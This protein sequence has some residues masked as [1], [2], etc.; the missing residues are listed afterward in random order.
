MLR[1]DVQVL[2]GL[3]IGL[4]LFAAVVLTPLA[5]RLARRYEV[6]D[7]P[8]EAKHHRRVTPYL[9]GLASAVA[10]VAVGGVAAGTREQLVTLLLGGVALT[11]VGL[12]D[13]QRP[14]PIALKLGVEIAAAAMLWLSGIRAELFGI[15][16]LDLALTVAWVVA[17]TNALNILDNMDG[18][19]AGVTAI[20]AATFFVI[21]AQAGHHLVGAMSL[22]VAGA[23]LGF[24]VHNFPPAR[25]F[26]GDA[27]TLL[28]GFLLA[29]IGLK[30]DLVGTN[31]FVRSSIPVLVLGVPLFDML[32]VVITR[33]RERR[34]IYLGGLDHT[35]HRLARRGLSART[36]ALLHYFAQG[37]LSL[38]AIALVHAT[39]G[40]AL[41]IVLG[42]CAIVA[43][44]L[45]VVLRLP[46][47]RKPE[48]SQR[49]HE[50]A[51]HGHTPFAEKR[52]GYS[53]SDRPS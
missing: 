43:I 20:S 41:A 24:L 53:R 10:L 13:D 39:W 28:F 51:P 48:D 14:V 7:H 2:Y 50:D 35:S 36:V 29:A 15:A 31:G 9:G 1:I 6:L 30:L 25:I 18:L 3:A 46:Y 45:W 37:A 23:S 42:T 32:V 49:I 17:V 40:V 4:P 12:I 33:A 47:G 52:A 16:P 38:L 44:G 34:P 22:A 8:T 21:S 5:A 27:G 26:L 11:I 19:A